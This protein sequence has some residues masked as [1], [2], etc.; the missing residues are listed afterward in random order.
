M[1]RNLSTGSKPSSTHI[2]LSLGALIVSLGIVYGD[3][4][5]S[6]LYVFKAMFSFHGFLT[7]PDLIKGA[8]SAIFWTLTLQTTLKYVLITLRADNH[9]EG[10]TF[11]LYAL[12]KKAAKRK[13]LYL[14]AIIGGAALL[15]D[16]VITCAITTTSA[17]EG[18]Q[19]RKPDT[20]VVLIVLLI[21][22]LL[23]GIQQLGTR[24]IGRSFGPIMFLWFSMM[25]ILGISQIVNY[26]QIIESLN[27][28]YTYNLLVNHP[29][30]FIL[31]GAVFLCTTGA[32]ALY[33]DLGHC[34]IK[35]IRI[36]WFF[37]KIMLILN[38]LGQAVWLIQNGATA[39]KFTN[40]FYAIMPEWFLITGI[41]MAT[42]AAIIA[43]QALISG[44]FT[45]V[46]EAISL[47][48]LPR[49]KVKYTSN[50]KGQVYIPRVN[51]ML[52]V[53]CCF[54]VLFFRESTRMEAA[55]GL[56][57]TLTMLM[58]TILMIFYLRYKKRLVLPIV[59][60]FAVG[61]GIIEGS[62]LIANLH[63]FIDGGWFTILLSMIFFTVMFC[64]YNG[65]RIKQR[66]IRFLDMEVYKPI[67]KDISEDEMIMRTA[68]NLVFFSNTSNKH[69]IDDK[70]IFS[71]TSH[72]PKRADIYW[73]IHIETV[74]EPYKCEYMVEPVLEGVIYRIYL[75][76]GFRIEPKINQFFV[77][78]LSDL[79]RSGEID[80]T[81]RYPSLRK[82][83]GTADYKFIIVDR[84]KNPELQLPLMKEIILNIYYWVRK[85][86]IGDMASNGLH[87]GNSILEYAPL[88]L[89]RLYPKPI[90]RVQEFEIL[91]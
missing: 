21:I 6:P 59:I 41:I 40:P 64:W 84:L 87:S 69:K 74:G 24:N 47:N 91:D 14:F 67:I 77:Q 13:S 83:N 89:D 5:T 35:N 71:I 51:A 31:L 46:G 60:I 90:K 68:T 43:S 15:A 30:S 42:L 37:V 65:R 4:G 27:P 72:T 79:Q 32:E 66:F 9:G 57:I 54:I 33:A 82:Y 19:M 29:G 56:A 20:P 75:H 76:L 12:I 80:N 10:G 49:L 78:I 34:G 38:Y 85:L 17:I 81:S 61:Y 63:K 26:P 52:W 48:F 7:N 39:T 25:G 86:G 23:F 45:I 18:I 22:C 50:I 44:A 3:I 28:Y 73:F 16:G 58:T 88:T 11:S 62:F 2:N 53:G 1:K 36:S 70:C 55:Y 8:V